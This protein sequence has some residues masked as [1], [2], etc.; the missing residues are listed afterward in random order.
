MKDKKI[1]SYH[2]FMFPFSIE[3]D[4]DK[5]S[6]DFLSRIHNLIKDEN[7][8]YEEFKVN[9]FNGEIPNYN[10]WVY[11]YKPVQKLLYNQK[12]LKD[13]TKKELKEK[14]KN[15]LSLYYSYEGFDENKENIYTILIRKKDKKLKIDSLKIYNLKIVGISLRIFRTGV[16][17]LSFNLENYNYSDLKDI[18]LINDYGRRIYPQYIS[19]SEDC[20]EKI[21]LE[22]VKNSF[23]A[24]KIKI[25]VDKKNRE[26]SENFESWDYKNKKISKVILDILG[27]KFQLKKEKKDNESIEIETII[28]D[29]MFTICWTGNNYYSKEFST[30]RNNDYSY[31]N[32]QE[33][34]QYIFIDGNG[35]TC[36]SKN[37]L[38]ELLKK[39]TYERWIDYGTLYGISRYSFVLLTSDYETLKE[40]HALYLT[41]HIRTMYYQLNVIC[42][43]QRATILN[44]K[45]RIS[46]FLEDNG[47]DYKKI[48][49]IQKDYL[50]FVNAMCFREITAQEQ[51]I[52]LYNM[53]KEI[54]EIDQSLRELES[55]I[56]ELNNFYALKK[57]EEDNERERK[58]SEEEK[59]KEKR[60]N[61]L[62]VIGG[63]LVL[64]SFSIGIISLDKYK[65][66]LNI[67]P[68]SIFNGLLGGILFIIIPL[69]FYLIFINNYISKDLE[70]KEV[71]KVSM[72]TFIFI[73]IIYLIIVA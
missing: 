31:C 55:E 63:S 52:E 53:S 19:E 70:K 38:K 51:G 13:L 25:K 23:L 4:T 46:E 33:W 72:F 49:I 15:E 1:Y 5:S 41:E 62:T 54:M 35:S 30:I 68:F 32:N 3:F 16:G 65:N 8:K 48:Q 26:Y 12:N 10:E 20:R 56:S 14:L 73:V 45:K 28:D 6:D 24:D 43:M 37:M 29:R 17:I 50:K 7:W 2:T 64:P 42:L 58:K 21:S 69:L 34:E 18:N 66:I 39:S 9:G 40:N 36:Q 11:F 61:Y 59:R 47:R 57:S 22:K 44:F 27:K 60:I 71:E 67:Y